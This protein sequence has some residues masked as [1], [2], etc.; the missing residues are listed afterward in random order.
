[1]N[2]AAGLHLNPPVYPLSMMRLLGGQILLVDI[3]PR[4][5]RVYN[6]TKDMV[7]IGLWRELSD[8]GIDGM[9]DFQGY[10]ANNKP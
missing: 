6:S 8:L 5:A 2:C 4:R 7:V 9:R 10:G 3:K 1:M